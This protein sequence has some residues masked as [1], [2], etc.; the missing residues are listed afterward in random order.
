[1]NEGKNLETLVNK[2]KKEI[3][4]FKYEII[5]VDDN[6]QDKTLFFLDKLKKKNKFIRYYI[7]KKNPDLSRSCILGF[8]KS[9]YKR[10]VVMDGDL[11]HDPKY[12]PKM[13]KI[14]HK[15]KLDIVVAARDFRKFSIQGLSFSRFTA[16]KI[17]I[18]IFYIFVGTKTSDPMSG[19]FMFDKKIFF[20]NK[21][22]LFGKGYKILS[23]LIYSNKDYVNV[24]DFYITFNLRKKGYSKMNIKV[25]LNII[26][27]IFFNFFRKIF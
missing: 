15:D 10:I 14:F 6:S 23:D 24:K 11:Q 21:N 27:F 3:N 1:M 22:R 17:L 26:I 4:Q 25:L 20:K 9:K 18:Y 2:I 19:F 12:I 13:I 8:I 16:S 7:R 5:F